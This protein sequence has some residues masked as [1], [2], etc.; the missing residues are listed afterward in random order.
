MEKEVLELRME[1]PVGVEK[2]IKE[3]FL[4]ILKSFELALA[5]S[6]AQKLVE[7]KGIERKEGEKLAEEIKAGVARRLGL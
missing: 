1:F 2:E 3:S 6:V 4:E 7:A 5:F